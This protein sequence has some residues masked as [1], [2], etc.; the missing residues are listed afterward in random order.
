MSKGDVV[1][2]LTFEGEKLE[3]RRE[4]ALKAQHIQ[5]MIEDAGSDV[6]YGIPLKEE[7]CTYPIMVKMIHFLSG[8]PLALEGLS[9]NGSTHAS[10][11]INGFCDSEETILKMTRA[12]MFLQIP[13][14]LCKL[15]NIPGILHLLLK[16]NN[17]CRDTVRE[18]IEYKADILAEN[19]K[20]ENI[21][22]LAKMQNQD[23]VVKEVER[24][25]MLAEGWTQLMMDAENGKLDRMKDLIALEEKDYRNIEARTALHYAA[26]GGN[27]EV[28]SLLIEANWGVNAKDQVD[29]CESCNLTLPKIRPCVKIVPHSRLVTWTCASR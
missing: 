28:V 4:I 5:E 7:S 29:T 13:A 21:L 18:L 3:V 17:D 19:E 15:A 20:G 14:I 1:V 11:T 25:L 22:D 9:D 26:K 10:Q 6:A 8:T 24:G 12:A 2:L 23:D 16:Q 27:P